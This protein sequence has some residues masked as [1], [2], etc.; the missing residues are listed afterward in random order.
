MG[1]RG[2]YSPPWGNTPTGYGALEVFPS[3]SSM[4]EKTKGLHQ[5][6]GPPVFIDDARNESLKRLS[7]GLQAE[8]SVLSHPGLVTQMYILTHHVELS[9]DCVKGPLFF[10]R[11]YPPA[12]E[13]VV[14]PTARLSDIPLPHY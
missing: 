11:F 5:I 7:S 9:E 4:R 10:L 2:N 13:H 8:S 1:T 3:A 6:D 12:E 14:I